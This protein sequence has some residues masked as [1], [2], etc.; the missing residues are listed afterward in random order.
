MQILAAV[1]LGDRRE[2]F[3][4][5]GLVVWAPLLAIGVPPGLVARQFAAVVLVGSLAHANIAPVL[6]A[7]HCHVHLKIRRAR[8]LSR[9]RSAVN[10]AA[11][12]IRKSSWSAG[13]RP[14]AASSLPGESLNRPALQSASSFSTMVRSRSAIVS[15]E[16]WVIRPLRA[17][18]ITVCR[19]KAWARYSAERAKAEKSTWLFRTDRPTDRT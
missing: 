17:C 10:S 14:R 1:V 6:R 19:Q 11:F 4:G 5:R 2:Y 12:R 3:L 7:P 9:A 8:S 18:S 15:S 16:R 13:S